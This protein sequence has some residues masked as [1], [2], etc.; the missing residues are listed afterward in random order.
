VLVDRVW[1]RGVRRDAGRFE[2]WLPEIA[3]SVDQRTW[4]G[5]DPTRFDAFRRRFL[6]ELR[7]P[8]R[9]AVRRR[10]LA[11]AHDG[12]RTLLTAAPDLDHSQAAILAEWLTKDR[13][14]R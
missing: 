6:E 5:H 9:Q 12:Q 8:A 4:C 3:P 14:A 13:R 1:P 11:L 7:D 2:E 10:L